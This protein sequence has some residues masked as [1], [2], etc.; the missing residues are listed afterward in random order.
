[1]L[2]QLGLETLRSIPKHLDK[3]EK[4]RVMDLGLVSL[5]V[6]LGMAR[7][8]GWEGYFPTYELDKSKVRANAPKID[9]IREGLMRRYSFLLDDT[10]GGEG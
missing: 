1:M 10:S 2:F 3:E 6:V 4:V 9:I 8:T 5:M 7:W